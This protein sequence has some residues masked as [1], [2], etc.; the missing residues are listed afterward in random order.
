VFFLGRKVPQSSGKA[1]AGFEGEVNSRLQQRAEGV[2]IRHTLNGNSLKMYD[3]FGLILRIETT[4]NNVSFFQHY[5]TV[6]Q[7]DGRTVTQ[8]APMKKSIYSLPVLREV[9]Q[10]ANRRYL[11]FLSTLD[12]PTA[13][14]DRLH[15]IS[16]PVRENERSYPGLNFFSAQDQILIETLARGEFNLRGL[17]NK[18]LRAHLGKKTSGQV[19]RLL[20]RLR[21]H[22]LVKKVGHT[23]RYYL[24]L[25]G[26]QVIASG[27]KLKNMV[28]IPQLA[29]GA[30]R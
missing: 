29:L 8:W 19:S 9:L 5:R 6:E 14:I 24:T 7:R 1:H 13:G 12:D 18:N 23:Y 4:V 16:E 26:K 27:L 15:K 20:K 10:A 30:A 17:Q 28:L 2:R 11:E 25:L 22:G 21:L 3:K